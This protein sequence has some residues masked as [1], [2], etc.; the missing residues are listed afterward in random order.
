MT[1]TSHRSR[2]AFGEAISPCLEVAYQVAAQLTESPSQA[3][4]CLAEAAILGSRA[5]PDFE[6]DTDIRPVFLGL[7]LQRCR[8]RQGD[9]GERADLTAPSG[10]DSLPLYEAAQ[11][12]PWFGQEPDP[13]AVL[14]ARL[15]TSDV[16]SALRALPFELRQVAALYYVAE[17]SY[18]E[19]A[20]ALNMS[21]DLVRSRL[22]QAR[23]EMQRAMCVRAREVGILPA[24]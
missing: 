16:S 20:R 14:F 5:Q 13:A 22:H 19:L 1:A 24:A 8:S 18:A 11:S 21:M 4:D 15:S 12:A 6:T 17:F 10:D 3:E 9:A 2:M 7:V 23:R